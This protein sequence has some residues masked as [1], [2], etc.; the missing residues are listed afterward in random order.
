MAE[1]IDWEVVAQRI[2]LQSGYDPTLVE[3]ITLDDLED[4][5]G[6]TVEEIKTK[7]TEI[8]ENPDITYSGVNLMTC[9]LYTSPSPR[10]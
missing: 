9:L 10:D 3:G 8:V 4:R 7:A 1:P 6:Q 2:A 5:L